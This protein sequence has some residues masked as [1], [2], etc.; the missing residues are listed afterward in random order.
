M[1]AIEALPD[2]F[3]EYYKNDNKIQKQESIIDVY[4]EN[5]KPLNKVAQMGHLLA[6]G[7]FK[8]KLIH[9]LDNCTNVGDC[10]LID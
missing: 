10:Q 8:M 7:K 3:T 2:F 5:L 4:I 9:M 1:S 6:L